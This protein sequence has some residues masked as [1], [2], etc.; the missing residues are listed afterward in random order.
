V[1]MLCPVYPSQAEQQ[2]LKESKP[3]QITSCVYSNTWSVDM[4]VQI[5]YRKM[6]IDEEVYN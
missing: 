6:S 3:E 5:L 2:H 1:E 4:H